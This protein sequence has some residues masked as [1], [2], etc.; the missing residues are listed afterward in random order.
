MSSG[1][2]GR[3]VPRDAGT[4]LRTGRPGALWAVPALGFFALFALA[5]LAIVAYLSFTSWNGLGAP[6][7]VGWANWSRL[8][9]DRDVRE[10]AWHSLLLTVGTWAF[11]TP[12]ALLLGVW[13]AGRGRHRA[14]LSAVFLLPLLLSSAA[15]A[16]V[17]KSLLDPNFGLV[18]E[19]A[20]VLGFDDASWFSTPEG[21]FSALL[22]VLGWQFIPFHALLY[23]GA[24]RQV[25]EVLHQA[26][27]LDGAGRARRFWSITLP[28]LRNT[29]VASSVLMVVGSL[30]F[31]DTVLILTGGGPGTSTTVVPLLVYR[32]G[33][34]GFEMGYASAI[35]FALV[36]VSTAVSLLLV[37]LTGFGR[38]SA[39]SARDGL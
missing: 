2:P 7:W 26:A 11:Q 37:R 39:T 8:L 3:A 29:V 31:F 17:W 33:F 1:R 24:A 16:L 35:A 21:A 15:V 30:T 38:M 6:E 5:P 18:A 22:F 27:A 12:A 25:P 10:A 36:L 14:V 34:E 19:V 9:S 20:P 32:N 23:Q 4:R 28:Q 13:S